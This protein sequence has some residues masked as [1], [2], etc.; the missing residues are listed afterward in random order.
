MNA[1]WLLTASRLTSS[2]GGLARAQLR[3]SYS[4]FIG[5]K[6]SYASKQYCTHITKIKFISFRTKISELNRAKL[7]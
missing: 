3:R 6:C 2:V 1:N 4:N 7:Y 5:G